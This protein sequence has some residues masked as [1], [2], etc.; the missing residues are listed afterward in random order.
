MKLNILLSKYFIHPLILG[1]KMV[2]LCAITI[3]CAYLLYRRLV[4]A[5]T[6]QSTHA[7]NT[8]TASTSRSEATM[9]LIHDDVVTRTEPSKARLL[10]LELQSNPN[11]Q[12]ALE[13][14]QA[15]ANIDRLLNHPEIEKKLNS[16]YA[17]AIRRA[18]HSRVNEPNFAE[19][20][21]HEKYV[22]ELFKQY[23]IPLR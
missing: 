15:R 10:F 22:D 13:N 3:G 2:F 4:S 8:E 21:S 5:P 23:D 1:L 7:I 16:W 9:E 18:I 19:A 11:F 20:V 6:T 14:P 12:K 17:I